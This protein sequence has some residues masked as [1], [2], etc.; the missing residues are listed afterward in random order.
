MIPIGLA[1]EVYILPIASVG[2][3]RSRIQEFCFGGSIG[4][5]RRLFLVRLGQTS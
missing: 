3:N 4:L 2:T 1:L 5:D